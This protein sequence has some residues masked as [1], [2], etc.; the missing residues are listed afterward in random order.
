MANGVSEADVNSQKIQAASIDVVDLS[1]FQAK[2]AGF[3]MSGNAIYSGKTSIKDPNSGIYI[4]TVG[5]GMGDGSLTGKNEAPLQAYA[6]G[7]FK[8]TGKNSSFDFNTVTGELNI[9]ASS[10]KISSKSVATKEEVNEL[11]DEITTLMTMTSSKGI[12]F[13]NNAYLQSC[14]SRYITAN[15]V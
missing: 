11:K 2:I 1:A 9:S 10:L 14:I 3:D 15:S 4:S 12:A 7:S 13:K 5:I 8:L 6:D